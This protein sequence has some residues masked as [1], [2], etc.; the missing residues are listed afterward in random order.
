M[1]GVRWRPPWAKVGTFTG[2][3]TLTWRGPRSYALR[4]VDQ[5]PFS[6]TLADG[7]LTIT[8]GPMMTD[9][10]SVPKFFWRIVDPW[11]FLP[12]YMI[13]DSLFQAHHDGKDLLDFDATNLCLAE[14]IN[15]LIQTGRATGGWIETEA[16]YR[17]VSSRFGRWVWDHGTAT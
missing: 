16:I 7:S 11:E 6:Y 14:A 4:F 9:G 15:T 1:A 8:P 5:P 3:V 17:A 13:H 12:A 10:G 2:E